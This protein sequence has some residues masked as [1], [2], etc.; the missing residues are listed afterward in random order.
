L[1][2]V[3]DPRIDNEKLGRTPEESKVIMTELVLPAQTN[4]HGNLLGGQLMHLMDIAGALSCRRHCRSEVSTVAVDSIEFKHPVRLGELITITSKLI[5][6]GRTSMKVEIEV[7]AEN[8]KT[9]AVIV[10]NTAFFTFVALGENEKPINVP[11]L[12]PQTQEERRLFDCEEQAYRQR[13]KGT[14]NICGKA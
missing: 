12:L 14:K 7:A 6:A 9:G 8:L 1:D 5:W 3:A 11:A 4:L 2:N 13:K 10:T